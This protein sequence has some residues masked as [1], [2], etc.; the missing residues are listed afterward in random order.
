VLGILC[1][2]ESFPSILNQRGV[3]RANG[4]SPAVR[5]SMS[6][7]RGKNPWVKVFSRLKKPVTAGFG[8]ACHQEGKKKSVGS[9]DKEPK[10]GKKIKSHPK[11][12]KGEHL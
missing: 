2:V 4:F 8:K 9:L 3:R 7:S 5:H 12:K 1:K 6:T 11:R 10:R